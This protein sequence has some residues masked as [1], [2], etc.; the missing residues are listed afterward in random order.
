MSEEEELLKN[1]QR[2]DDE[3]KRFSEGGEIQRIQNGQNWLQ[4]WYRER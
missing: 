2:A 3:W 1:L 4:L